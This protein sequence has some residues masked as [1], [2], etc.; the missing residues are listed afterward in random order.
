MPLILNDAALARLLDDDSAFG[1]LTTDALGIGQ[2]SGRIEFKARGALRLC[3]VE[4][5]IRLCQLAGVEATAQAASGDALAAGQ[6]I[7]HASGSAASL[8]RAWKTAQVLIEW[9][10]GIASATADLVHAAGRVPVACTRK[11]APGTKALSIK[12]VHAG[13]ATMHRLGLSET[14]LVFPEHRVFLCEPPESTIARLKARE[15]EKKIVVEVG[16]LASAECWAAADADVLQ[17]EKF[18]PAALAECH[19]LLV[20]TAHRPLIA[21]AGGVHAGNA[22]A[23]ADAGADLLVSSAPFSAPPRDV[24]VRFHAC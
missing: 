17:L 19:H 14:I 20:S 10:S 5:A 6:D 16:D 7:L 15:P 2:K 24:A 9:A 4:E 13:G 8:H 18:T 23:Y 1:D 11:S 12:A 22:G 3:G 21:A